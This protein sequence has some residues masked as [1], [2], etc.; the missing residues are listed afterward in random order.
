ML[1]IAELARDARRRDGAARVEERDHQGGVAARE[2]R[3]ART[4]CSRS[5]ASRTR[6]STRRS[7][8][9]RLP[10]DADGFLAVPTEPGLGVTLDED[11][12]AQYRVD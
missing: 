3:A 12:M 4:R 10:I 5:T 11:V 8:S 9:E 1:R 6:R 2:R 7:R